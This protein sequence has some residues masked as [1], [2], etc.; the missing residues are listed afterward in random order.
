MRGEK[1]GV[2]LSLAFLAVAASYAAD[3]KWRPKAEQVARLEKKLLLPAGA[4][5]LNKY[6]RY[7]WG[8]TTRNGK[9]IYGSLLSLGGRKPGLVIA[10][11]PP[12]DRIMDGGCGVI[13][14]IYDL[15][16]DSVSAQCNGLA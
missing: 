11:R 3:L 14:V 16:K 6:G 8:E 5:S 10:D 7:Y 12:G 4:A 15:S 9:V 2:V 1:M 13:S